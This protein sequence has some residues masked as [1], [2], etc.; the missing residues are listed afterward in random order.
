MGV[1]ENI[2]RTLLLKYSW[3]KEQ[4][5]SK[6]TDSDNLL[7]KVFNYDTSIQHKKSN[8]IKALCP[9]CYEEKLEFVGM[10]C[11]H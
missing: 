6:F 11:G 4:V 1:E 7:K 8:K 3:D 10:E 5:I 2:S 9:V